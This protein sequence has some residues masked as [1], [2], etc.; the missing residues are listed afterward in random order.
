MQTAS[1]TGF[2]K[3]LFYMIAFYYIF[4]FLAKLFLP[5]LVKKVVEKA[6][7]N[8]QK[9]QQYAQ[10]NT[11]KKTQSKDEV[12]YNTANAKNPRETKKVGDYVDYEEID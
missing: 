8:M 1:F 11:W 7:E 2:I 9:Q 4:R 5:L 6:G 3:A 10:D 12:I